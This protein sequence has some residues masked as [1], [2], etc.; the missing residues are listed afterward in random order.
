MA[1][2]DYDYMTATTRDKFIPKVIDNIYDS[3]A[4]LKT[5]LIDGRIREYQKGGSGIV[6]PLR[7]E[8]MSAHGTYSG[9]DTFDVTPPDNI[10]A[11]KHTWG[12]Y[13]ASIAISGDDEDQNMGDTQVVNLLKE[14]TQEAEDVMKDD[15]GTDLFQGNGSDEIIGLDTAVGSGSYGGI[16]GGDYT[17]WVSGTSST[18][19]TRA[20]LI[21][22]TD[23]THY[24]NLLFQAAARSAKHKNEVPNLIVMPQLLWDIYE[25]TLQ[26]GARY[27]KTG[28]GQKIAD[29]G[30]D[31]LEF[32]KTPIISD[33]LCPAGY[34]F[35]LNTSFITWYVHPS[36]NFKFTGFKVPTNQDGRIGQ[37][38]LKSQIALSNRR[39]H[40][41]FSGFP[42]S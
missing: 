35:F 24:I 5:L 3:S 13:Y 16:D 41:K 26:A 6:E 8:K 42:T 38:L 14:R 34:V 37:I 9:W 4:S 33:E 2:L 20:Q 39:M 7:Y 31:V 19:H 10:S 15:L 40:Y 32:R 23:T 28:R 30:F 25:S 29:A 11:S 12:N 1:A 21:D 18:A 17:W 22:P 27:P 36:K